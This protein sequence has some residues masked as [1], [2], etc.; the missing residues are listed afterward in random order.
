VRVLFPH[1]GRIRLFA[2]LF[3]LVWAGLVWRLLDIQVLQSRRYRERAQEQHLREVTL[4]SRRGE[5]VDTHGR[6]L[7]A[8]RLLHTVGIHPRL[9]KE[10]ATVAALLDTLLG[11][12][13]RHWRSQIESH[14]GFFYV[15]RRQELLR[16]PPAPHRLPA[17]VE[18]VT[19]YRRTY[20]RRE[21]AAQLIGHVGV[22][23]EG[24]E[25]LER[26]YEE[27]LR[28]QPGRLI[29][30]VDATGAPIP[31]LGET[32]EEPMDGLR[33]HLTLDAVIQ[34][35]VQEELTR[36]VAFSEAKGGTAVALDPRTGAVLAMANVPSYDPNRP[37]TTAASERR[38]RAVTD[39]F[40]PGSVSKIVTFAAALDAGRFS[41]ADTID[42]GNGVIQLVG[43]EIRDTH[44]HGRMSLGEVLGQSS[45]VGTILI[46][47]RIGSNR[48][49]R[50]ARDFGYGQP[51]GI[52]LPAEEG[53]LLRRIPDWYGPALESLSIGYGV[54][55]TALQVAGAFAAV[56]NGGELMQP[57]VLASVEDARGRERR[58]GN[59][60]TVRR[61]MHEETS[62]ILRGFL[63]EAVR[64]GTGDL[65]AVPGIEVAGKTGTARKAGSAGYEAGAY[66]S[67]FCGF[68]PAEAPTFL[69]FVVIDEPARRYYAREVSAPVFARV[70]KRL[71]SHPEHPLN[72]LGLPVHQ[73][74]DR[75]AP[76][77]PDLRRRPA[78]EAARA[79]TQR[80]LRVRF[81]G[82]GPVVLTQEP[83]PLSPAE[84][85][86]VVLLRLEE[87]ETVVDGTTVPDLRG[88]TLREAVAE[89]SALGLSLNAQGSGVIVSQDPPPG[90]RVTEGA[91]L[92]VRARQPGPG[93]GL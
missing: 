85:G 53:G 15:A 22:D 92:S 44:A 39:P 66:N 31:G 21:L 51:T 41:P 78:E 77:I 55:V 79:L 64:E 17:G 43:A 1:P 9:V 18:I 46:A 62:A 38:N 74:A 88:R 34:E 25:G 65:A 16:E 59:P 30:Q 14:S 50:T 70:V 27:F 13:P 72:G 10:P 63:R 36:G 71:A 47:Q 67:S 11:N 86:Q 52:D 81:V 20:P 37:E 32:R 89:A 54:S 56:A 48:L 49:Y 60:R 80:G 28:G 73:V 75:P 2:L 3:A 5:I 35:V 19:E 24:M 4:P 26:Q 90:R 82:R 69:L 84:P 42:G 6:L 57:Y 61:V 8:D 76:V 91:T 29:H 93:A 23:G 12:G 68:L 45:N 7:A 33:L 87:T 40:E 83:A 58:V